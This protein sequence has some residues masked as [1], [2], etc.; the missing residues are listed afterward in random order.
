MIRINK[1]NLW[2]LFIFLIMFIGAMN[3]ILTFAALGISFFV[4]MLIA[5]ETTKNKNPRVCINIIIILCLQNFAIGLGAH[6]ASN[7]DQSLKFITQIPF[8]VTLLTWI[9]IQ[10]NL[11]KENVKMEKSK[12][13]F[14]LLLIVILSSFAFGKGSLSSILM[15]I[16]NLTIFY[17]T[18][19]IGKYYLK[20]TY[21]FE[22]YLKAFNKVLFIMLIVGI[23][24]LIGGYGLYSKIG[25]DEVYIAKGNTNLAGRMNGRFYTTIISRKFVRMGS[26]YYE[27]VNLAYLYAVGLIV[28]FFYKSKNN[29]FNKNRNLNIIISGTGLFLTFGKGG[30]L[31]VICC[32]G[33]I[34]LEK[35]LS[36]ILIRVNKNKIFW[37][38]TLFMILIIS[39]FCIFYYK[40]VGAA[41]LPHFWGI[42]RTWKNV[43][44]KPFGHGIGTGGNMAALF[45][46]DFGSANYSLD[47]VWLSTGGESAIMSFMYQIGVHG[48]FVM[49]VTMLYMA[50][51]KKYENNIFS[52]IIRFLPIA[53][54]GIAILQENTFTPQCIIP[55][56][57]VIGAYSNKGNKEGDFSN[58]IYNNSS[59][60]QC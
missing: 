56:M 50:K 47:S 53:I 43:K 2:F 10:L 55:F 23:I 26:L 52:K 30:W 8:M 31:I 17:M 34:I 45:N 7:Y 60:I 16:R 36:Q 20:D 32:V 46:S 35:I 38:T 40:N 27:P 6:I 1:L 13:Y 19:E 41:A 24:L 15:N 14:I 51:Q 33:F 4:S 29:E 44:L 22:N 18:F 58:E 42:I 37:I 21:E 28:N 11:I 3:R 12:F 25:M 9:M 59:G 48:V 5:L 54:F 49:L 57:F 39:I